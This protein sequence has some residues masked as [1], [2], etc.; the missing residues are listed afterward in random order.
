MKFSV[1]SCQTVEEDGTELDYAPFGVPLEVIS[2]RSQPLSTRD[3]TSF[4][5][6]DL[7]IKIKNYGGEYT[8][9]N[10]RTNMLYTVGDFKVKVRKDI[11]EIT[12]SF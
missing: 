7:L 2:H 6:T 8:I 9:L 3:D 11:K 1:T 5:K 4:A 12:L 10:L